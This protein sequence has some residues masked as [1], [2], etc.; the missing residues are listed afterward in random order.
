MTTPDPSAQPS[1]FQIYGPK[2]LVLGSLSFS[3]GELS[4]R[5]TRIPELAPILKSLEE[6]SI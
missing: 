5:C 6:V 3:I 4:A 1:V 2:E